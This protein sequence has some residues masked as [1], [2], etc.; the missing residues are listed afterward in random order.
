[1]IEAGWRRR[2]LWFAYAVGA[3]GVV[4]AMAACESDPSGD[5]GGEDGDAASDSAV[6]S[7]A[8]V[9]VADVVSSPDS[10]D[11]IADVREADPDAWVGADH[12]VEIPEVHVAPDAPDAPDAGLVPV[13]VGRPDSAVGPDANSRSD[14]GDHGTVIPPSCDDGNRCNG[15][16]LVGSNGQCVPGVPLTCD[17]G[18]VCNGVEYC[19]P[20]LG[21]QAGPPLSCDDGNV[22]NGAE[23][24]SPNVGCQG[25]TAPI[26]DDGNV[27][28]GAEYCSPASGCLGGLPLPCDD[29][30][31]CNGTESCNPSSGCTNGT[32]LSCDDGNAC[33]GAE[34]CNPAQGCVGGVSIQCSSG[35]HCEEPGVCVDEGPD[36]CSGWSCDDGF[37][38]SED[39][40][41]CECGCWDPDCDSPGELFNCGPGQ[42]CQPPGVCEGGSGSGGVDGFD[43]PVGTP[44]ALGGDGFVT[45]ANDGDGYYN[46]QDFGSSGHCG[47]DWNGE[48]GGNSDFGD[49][50]Y[51]AADGYVTYAAH[52][53]TG[54][55]NI[56]TID[57]EVV[58]A[59]APGWETLQTQYAHLSEM[60]VQLGD[61][62][63][64]GDLIGAIGSADGAYY[65]HLHFELRW[66]EGQPPGGNGYDCPNDSTG[67]TDPSGFIDAHR[68]WP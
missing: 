27:C 49:P 42:T 25:G 50:V 36:T 43:Y 59:G 5:E 15:P 30:N 44:I 52:A 8:E 39:G 20:A 54:W 35:A 57:H 33:N 29:G 38:G 14:D 13:D 62:V 17:D 28:N 37:Y 23:Y 19:S 31:L 68:V 46:A 12:G 16:E 45:P 32:S 61:A 7:G 53:G 18:N 3:V 47:E 4:G 40:C 56:I 24:C 66:D 51:A 6:Q 55:G 21:C 10:A 67:M 60:H 2:V 63:K 11:P 26:C 58:G 22:C 1:M 34:S 48:G 9:S 41:D 65:A 64:R